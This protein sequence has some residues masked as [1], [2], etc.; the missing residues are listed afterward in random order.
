[1]KSSRGG[2]RFAGAARLTETG[3]MADRIAIGRGCIRA[4][5]GWMGTHRLTSTGLGQA[6]APS[7][8]PRGGGTGRTCA[9]T[10]GVPG[11]RPAHSDVRG[12]HETR[13]HPVN[14]GVSITS[15]G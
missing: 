7:P 15:S 5:C 1:M 8:E 13:K 3:R 12:A 6:G 4:R 14:R 11:V 2:A 10:G 9:L